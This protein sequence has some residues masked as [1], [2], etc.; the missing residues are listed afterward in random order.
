MIDDSLVVLVDARAERRWHAR[1]ATFGLLAVLAAACAVVI[2][3]RAAL[4]SSDGSAGLAAFV[5]GELTGV[6]G[7][8]A[9]FVMGRRLWYRCRCLVNLRAPFTGLVVDGGGIHLDDGA[10]R[11][12]LPWSAVSRIALVPGPKRHPAVI[13]VQPRA[14]APADLLA[15]VRPWRA[16][17]LWTAGGWAR[18]ASTLQVDVGQMAAAV[19][20]YSGR[21]V[22]VEVAPALATT[23]ST[24]RGAS[25]P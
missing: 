16:P 10:A 18:N 3:F 11:L 25:T 20:H 8:L 21:T 24:A 14:D 2:G 15:A 6:L 4:T 5:A 17:A 22:A 23:A 7:L 12:Q 19:W 9:L 1:A 13:A